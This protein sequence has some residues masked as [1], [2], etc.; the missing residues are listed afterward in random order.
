MATRT[1]AVDGQ[2]TSTSL[3]SHT[4]QIME[5]FLWNNKLTTRHEQKKHQEIQS[6][7]LSRLKRQAP[8][9]SQDQLGARQWSDPDSNSSSVIEQ[10]DLSR[11]R[12][13]NSRPGHD[14]WPTIQREKQNNESI[15][16]QAVLNHRNSIQNRDILPQRMHSLNIQSDDD[17]DED[18]T[19]VCCDGVQIRE[20]QKNLCTI[21]MWAIVILFIINHFFAHMASYMHKPKNIDGRVVEL[22]AQ[23]NN[24]VD[25]EVIANSNISITE[26]GDEG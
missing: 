23:A 18:N 14:A 26:L 13:N 5:A 25:L 11:P 7:I 16:L 8:T 6:L 1:R 20:G 4:Q 12:M 15:N 9:P 19:I 21:A 3:P 22:G 17:D 24:G 10:Y 2:S